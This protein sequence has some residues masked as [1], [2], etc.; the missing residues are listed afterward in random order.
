MSDESRVPGEEN[1]A[2][3]PERGHFKKHENQKYTTIA[4][5][6][7]LPAPFFLFCS[8]SAFTFLKSLPR[9]VPSSII[10]A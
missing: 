2:A 7:F 3:T 9:S 6:S 10:L 5:M 4:F 8:R 1:T